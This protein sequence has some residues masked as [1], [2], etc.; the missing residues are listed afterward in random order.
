MNAR[1]WL[2]RAAA[3]AAAWGLVL[4]GCG[5]GVG[6]GGTGMASGLTQGTVNGF[7][8]VIVDGDRFDDSAIATYSETAPGTST[9]TT[10]RLGARVEVESE[11]GKARRLRVD[12]AV[13]GAVEVLRADG[14]ELLGQVVLVNADATRGPVTQFSGGYAG[15][16]SVRAGDAVEVHAFLLRNAGGYTL[17]ATRIERRATLPEFLKVSGLASGVGG[18]GFQVGALRV[19]TGGATV[20]PEGAA[21]ADGQA[22]SVLAPATSLATVQG[23]TPQLHAAQVRIR[24]LGRP[25][26]RVA[27]SG[28]VGMLDAAAATFDLGGI[29]VDYRAAS[30]RPD[31]AALV[32][33]RYVQ[34]RGTLGGDGTIVAETVRVLDGRSDA[35]ASLK[36]TVVGYDAAT[37][38]FQ[39]RGVD[40]DAS[41]AEVE[42]CPAGQVAEGLFVEVE[43][44]LGATGVI[45]KSVHCEDE[46]DGAV[47]ERKGTASNVDTVARRFTLTLA[48]G[49]TLAVTWSE[50]T[51]FQNVSA[52]T[53]A[54]Q[55][56]EVEGKLVEGVMQ[57]RKIEVETED[58]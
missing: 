58:D 12:A 51:F 10:A 31:A 30:V 1:N 34:V 39:V 5:G 38:R 54:G 11:Q 21:L 25:G 53:L 3:L 23:A 45:A 6:S 9:Q 52:A 50:V 17:Q 49:G 22:V 13:V 32:A 55:R 14:F 15:L 29:R 40:V 19:L 33:G 27:T 42:G 56:V 16:G 36:G 4:A 26:D 48:T 2:M 35:E 37:Q 57:A 20:L 46:P 44:R 47:V 18:A 24:A 28:L 43:G 41:Q 8:S 7:G